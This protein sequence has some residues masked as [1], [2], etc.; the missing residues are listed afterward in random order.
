M[1]YATGRAYFDADSHVFESP[2]FYAP[3]A[4]TWVRERMAP[5]YEDTVRVGAVPRSRARA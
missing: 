3:H 4:P 2:D 1:P 5:L